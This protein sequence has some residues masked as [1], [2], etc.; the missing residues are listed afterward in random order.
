MRILYELQLSSISKVHP[1]KIMLD[2]D[3]NFTFALNLLKELKNYA[4]IFVLVPLSS[5]VESGEKSIETLKKYNLNPYEIK[6]IPH[7]AE[8]RFFVSIEDYKQALANVS[9]D[10]I[11]CNDPAH[12]A[13]W[14]QLCKD[15]TK[16]VAYNH[17]ICFLEYPKN[18]VP[19]FFRQIEGEYLADLVFCNSSAMVSALM[20]QTRFIPNMNYSKF[21]ILYPSVDEETI[22]QYQGEKFE[23]N[24]ILFNHRLSTQEEYMENF[25]NFMSIVADVKSVCSRLKVL[26]T[27]P[28]GYKVKGLESWMKCKTLS[29]EEYVSILASKPLTC[30][31]FGYKRMWSMSLGEAN[32]FGSVSVVPRHSCFLEMYPQNYKYFFGPDN[33]N[34]AKE[35]L[36]FLLKH[37]NV[38]LKEGERLKKFVLSKFS[39][40]V[41]AKKA[42]IALK[43]LMEEK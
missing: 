4:D 3:S 33:L 21:K 42:Y 10:V 17:W 31:F 32:G 11:F 38:R 24:L 1:G 26:F 2:S 18:R 43:N 27:N 12:V 25:Q 22:M 28:S 41:L 8:S 37:P 35:K 9:P 15:D 19:Y 34:E 13:N 20:H 16:I 30:A 7:P 29:R 6:F 14:K 40:K 39:N 23:K 36:I 5:Q